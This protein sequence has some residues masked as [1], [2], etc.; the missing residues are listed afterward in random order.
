MVNNPGGES[1]DRRSENLNAEPPVLLVP[2]E[3]ELRSGCGKIG[4]LLADRVGAV[5]LNTLPVK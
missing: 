1:I 2:P 4:G 3:P 5:G